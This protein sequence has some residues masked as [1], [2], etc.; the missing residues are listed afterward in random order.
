MLLPLGP[1][2]VV[3]VLWVGDVGPVTLVLPDA[4]EATTSV[5]EK[6]GLSW[7]AGD[8]AIAIAALILIEFPRSW[9]S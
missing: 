5:A 4:S 1:D 8:G 7:G 9:R 6:G 2:A 3:G